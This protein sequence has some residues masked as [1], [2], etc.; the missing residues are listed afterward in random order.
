[1]RPCLTLANLVLLAFAVAGAE[2][3][4]ERAS[5]LVGRWDSVSLVSTNFAV[6]TDVT[7]LALCVYSVEVK[8]N[9]QSNSSEAWLDAEMRVKT[10][11]DPDGRERIASD[12]LGTVWMT[13]QGII[14][15]G[16]GGFMLHYALTNS[17]LILEKHVSATNGATILRLDF[18]AKLKKTSAN[19]GKRLW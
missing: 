9:L 4:P 17:T 5:Q 18:L 6:F 8:T 3:T 19:P 14:F 10:S 13:P 16:P 2:L 15:G 1:M 7:N 12:S 11:N